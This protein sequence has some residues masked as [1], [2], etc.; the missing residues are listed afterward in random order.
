M[1]IVINNA[2]KSHDLSIRCE[3]IISL[4]IV[5][6]AQAA[7]KIYEC[8]L[9]LLSSGIVTRNSRSRVSRGNDR[10]KPSLHTARDVTN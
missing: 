4:K 2:S 3:L 7:R 5:K 8:G 1:N 6:S 9:D 10:S